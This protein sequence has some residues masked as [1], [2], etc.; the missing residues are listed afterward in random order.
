VEVGEIMSLV[1]HGKLKAIRIGSNIRIP[2]VEFEQLLVTCA[3]RTR[4]G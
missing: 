4:A 3:A 1:K 2:A